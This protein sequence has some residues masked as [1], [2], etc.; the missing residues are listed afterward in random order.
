MP[1]L[2]THKILFNI[3]IECYLKI[4]YDISIRLVGEE[5]V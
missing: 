4:W 1:L 5:S 2:N 3:K